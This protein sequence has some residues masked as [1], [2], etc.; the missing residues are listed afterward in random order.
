[1]CPLYA[2]H[3]ACINSLEASYVGDEG[4]PS[5][6]MPTGNIPGQCS[7][8]PWIL[9]LKDM[10]VNASMLLSGAYSGVI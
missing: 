3:F 7:H 9:L 6:A 4:G 1:M 8:L 5:E 10:V 2:Q